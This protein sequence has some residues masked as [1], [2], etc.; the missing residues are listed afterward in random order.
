MSDGREERER[1]F[2]GSFRYIDDILSEDNP[3]FDRFVRVEGS[4]GH[5]QAE[6]VIYPPFL[7]LNKTTNSPT[8]SDYLGMTIQDSKCSFLISVASAKQR[9]PVERINYPSLKGN[10]PAV[11]GYGVFTG[12]LH[13]L[14]RICTRPVDF[15]GFAVDMSKCLLN[16]R[17]Y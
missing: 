4:E 12:Q 2:V 17:L 13:R 14:S 9:F 8:S 10:F 11:L 16:G 5:D 3:N 15:L 1:K 7:E 6:D